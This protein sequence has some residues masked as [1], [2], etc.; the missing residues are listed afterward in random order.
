MLETGSYPQHLKDRI[1]K[2]FGHLSNKEALQL[3]LTHRPPFMRYLI[4]SHLS[5]NNN[6]PEIASELFD[7]VAGKAE[8]IIASRKQ[9][10]LLYH[11]DAHP[12]DQKLRAPGPAITKAQLSLFDEPAHS[13]DY[14]L[15]T[16][17]L[18]VFSFHSISLFLN[19]SYF[20]Q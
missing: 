10:S 18:T 17:F 14:R 7:R 13:S 11:I 15:L 20:A 2:G 12:E 8:I 4:L 9:E 16:T 5:A 3:F 6:K 19:R 1:R